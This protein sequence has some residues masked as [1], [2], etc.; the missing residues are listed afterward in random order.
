MKTK[1]TLE[2]IMSAYQPRPGKTFYRRMANA[3]WQQPETKMVRHQTRSIR[4]RWIYAVAFILLLAILAV[5]IPPVRAAVSAWLGLSVAPSNQMPAQPVTLVAVS[6]SA[7]P[8]TPQTTPTRAAPAQTAAPTQA[9]PAAATNIPPQISQLSPQAGWNILVPG[10]LPEGYLFESAFFNPNQQLV[11]LT[12]LTT[13]PLPGAADPSLT[14]TQSI[15]LLQAQKNDFV[16]MQV[17]P[18]TNIEDVQVNGQPAVYAVGAWDTEFVPNAKDPNGGQMVSTWRNDLAV[19]NLYWQVGNIYL[20]LVTG[21]GSL[22]QQQLIALAAS[23]R[24]P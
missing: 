12:Y 23:I 15:T 14:A 3:P 21:D 19:Q 7:Q 17:A 13:Q 9:R 5:A 16:P 6:P 11:M 4:F 10:Q 8:A 22:S 20:V 18:A 1:H 2:E 24:E